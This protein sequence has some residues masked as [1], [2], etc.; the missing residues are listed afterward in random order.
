M[1][2]PELSDSDVTQIPTVDLESIP[3]HAP[4][5]PPLSDKSAKGHD[6]FEE[7]QNIGTMIK[8]PYNELI[9]SK[10]PDCEICCPVMC[11]KEVGPHNFIN[12]YPNIEY[13][14]S[15]ITCLVTNQKNEIVM[16]TL[17]HLEPSMSM[18]SKD[19]L[20]IVGYFNDIVFSESKKTRKIVFVHPGQAYTFIKALS[21]KRRDRDPEPE[22]E[23]EKDKEGGWCNIF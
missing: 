3:K 17:S 8:N 7:F 6:Y 4:P 14:D 16:I 2:F 23:E 1:S 11:T 19:R 10:V 15:N 22:K 13:T 21:I 12:L 9:K 18:N 20:A 5:L